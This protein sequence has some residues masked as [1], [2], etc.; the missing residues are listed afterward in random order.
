[1]ATDA[2]GNDTGLP[3]CVPAGLYSVWDDQTESWVI[4]PT[5]L[6]RAQA[7][8]QSL[9]KPGY[10]TPVVAGYAG[11]YSPVFDLAAFKR[12]TDR[13]AQQAAQD[14]ADSAR[15]AATVASIAAQAA[16]T[17]SPTKPSREDTLRLML[18]RNESALAAELAKKKRDRAEV[19]RL[20][21]NVAKLKG[22][23]GIKTANDV[24]L[25]AIFG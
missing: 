22:D 23:L 10:R 8:A 3:G 7:H 1:M 19:A 5:T 15:R 20:Q 16:A 12:Q 6:E 2:W 9:K 21:A 24:L 25:S 14:A 18:G 11:E 17:P 13:A 4:E